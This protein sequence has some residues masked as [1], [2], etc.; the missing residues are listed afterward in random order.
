M[1]HDR[2][3]ANPFAQYIEIR[4]KH[5]QNNTQT[6]DMPD[7]HKILVAPVRSGDCPK[8]RE[9]PGKSRRVDRSGLLSGH[10]LL[11]FRLIQHRLDK[12]CGIFCQIPGTCGINKYSP[13]L[14]ARHKRPEITYNMENTFK[15]CQ[16]DF[17][18]EKETINVSAHVSGVITTTSANVCRCNM[19]LVI[20]TATVCSL[21]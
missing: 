4:I 18:W 20:M 16:N 14:K 3:L 9:T 2:K 19:Y 12:P 5:Q 11:V 7:F 15:K 13:N 17:I 6:H 1:P 21:I 10:Y 8:F